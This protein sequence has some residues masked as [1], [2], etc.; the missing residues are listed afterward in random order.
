MSKSYASKTQ[1]TKKTR[2]SAS[3]SKSKGKAMR[4]NDRKML[5]SL[6]TAGSV[7]ELQQ[8]LSQKKKTKK[9]RTDVRLAAI[10]FGRKS[11]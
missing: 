10:L 5:D 2:S 1:M 8:A 11:C 7:A 4:T 9:I 3:A 6:N